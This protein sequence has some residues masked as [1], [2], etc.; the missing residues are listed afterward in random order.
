LVDKAKKEMN[1]EPR[2]QLDGGMAQ[3]IQ[4]FRQEGFL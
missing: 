4:W 1:F 2:F 3:T